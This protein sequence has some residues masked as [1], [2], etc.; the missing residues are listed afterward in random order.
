MEQCATGA[1]YY[2]LATGTWTLCTSQLWTPEIEAV[3]CKND[4]QK[5]VMAYGHGFT[6][7]VSPTGCVVARM[8]HDKEGV[9][10]AD[11][12]MNLI[13]V[14]KYFI[15]PAGHYSTPGNM[16]LYVDASPQKPVSI[17][18]EEP[19]ARPDLRRDPPRRGGRSRVAS[20]LLRCSWILIKAQGPLPTK[21]RTPAPSTAL[22]AGEPRPAARPPRP[23]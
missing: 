11:V 23:S 16:Q 13:P 15:D 2:A 6:R 22:A 19:R 5:A 20:E 17:L 9:L 12:D 3:C 18:D 7:I 10:Y 4:A 1:Q 14:A 8:A 21:R